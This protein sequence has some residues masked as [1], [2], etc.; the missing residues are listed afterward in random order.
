MGDTSDEGFDQAKRIR[1]GDRAAFK[2]LFHAHYEALTDFAYYY[3]GSLEVAEDLVQE[4]FFDLW[5][6][7]KYWHPDHSPRAFLYGAVRNQTLKYQRRSRV[8]DHVQEKEVLDRLPGQENPE[9]RLR[10][11]ELEEAAR[12]AI[13]ELPQRRRQI[14]ILSRQHDLTY[15]EIAIALD[16]SIKTV[17]TQMGRALDHLRDR[18]SKD[19]KQSGTI[20]GKPTSSR[21]SNHG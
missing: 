7:R 3:V 21:S 8:R 2:E 5:K 17:E 16:I 11:Q 20:W 4:V 12:R 9:W 10:N 19:V 1:R 18:L 6:R 13:N 15:A 14:F